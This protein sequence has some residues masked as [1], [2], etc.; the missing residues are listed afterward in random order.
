MPKLSYKKTSNCNLSSKNT[1]KQSLIDTAVEA[2]RNGGV[3]AYP[4][5]AVFG[6]GCDPDNR[7]ALNALLAL[8]QRPASK[9]LILI[10]ADVSQLVPYIAPVDEAMLQRALKTWPGP[11][12][13]LFPCARN[14]EPLLIG[15]FTT[16]AVRVTAHPVARELCQAFGK[17]I[18]STSA[19]VTGQLPARTV[20]EVKAQFA[21]HLAAIVDG[22][23]DL[24]AQPSEIRDLVSNKVIRSSS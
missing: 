20:A 3:I 9:G 22:S 6:L 7:A 14:I 8:K 17:A 24:Q 11:V 18:V 19:N 1:M 5:E 16:I 4:T 2:M 21:D 12:T 10:A 23:V 13:W 15:E